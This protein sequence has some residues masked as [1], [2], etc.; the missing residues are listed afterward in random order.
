M[1][2]DELIGLWQQGRFPFDR[3]LTTFPL[4]NINE[5]EK[6]AIRGDVV[7]PVLIPDGLSMR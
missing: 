7:K 5:A 4:D 6:A 2:F 1:R 3:L